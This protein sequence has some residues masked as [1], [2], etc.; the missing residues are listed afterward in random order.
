M[1]KFAVRHNEGKVD[2]TLLPTT[3][4]QEEAKVWMMGETKYGRD[5]WKQLW[6]DKTV[7]VAMASLLRHAFAILAGQENDPESGLDHAA[8]I[9]CNAAMILEYRKQSK[10]LTEDT[11]TVVKVGDRT[12]DGLE[13]VRVEGS[14]YRVAKPSRFMDGTHTS[15]EWREIENG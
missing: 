11:D 10:V 13:I 4:C 14:R 15:F 7:E 1:T 2:L 5:N 6:G 12:T 8:H 3:A 9:R